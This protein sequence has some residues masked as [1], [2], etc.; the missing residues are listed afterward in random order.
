MSDCEFNFSKFYSIFAKVGSVV[1]WSWNPPPHNVLV[2]SLFVNITLFWIKHHFICTGK[3]Y[4]YWLC[5]I[6]SN[7]CAILGFIPTTPVSFMEDWTVAEMRRPCLDN[8]I[9]I[10]RSW[11]ST[12]VIVT[13]RYDRSVTVK[14]FPFN[15]FLSQT[16]LNFSYYCSNWLDSEHQRFLCSRLATFRQRY[17]FCV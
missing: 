1:Q 9:S 6:N 16:F 3:H 5:F 4:I 12:F 7:S 11:H 2:E 13:P 10:R 15:P 14:Y 17:H 8:K